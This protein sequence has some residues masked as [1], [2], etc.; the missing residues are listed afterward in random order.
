MRLLRRMVCFFALVMMSH[1]R[2]YIGRAQTQQSP[3][4]VCSSFLTSSNMSKNFIKV[5]GG[6][7]QGRGFHCPLTKPRFSPISK[8]LR[9]RTVSDDL[10]IPSVPHGVFFLSLF[11]SMYVT[12]PGKLVFFCFLLSVVTWV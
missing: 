5:E 1:S 12:D 9:S 6:G 4:V 3:I 8:K 11:M 7:Y 10:F 2:I